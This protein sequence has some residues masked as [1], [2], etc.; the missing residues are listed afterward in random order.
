MISRNIKSINEFDRIDEG[1]LSSLLGGVKNFFTSKKGKVENILKKI[2]DARHEEVSNTISIEKEIQGLTKDNT[3]EYRFALTNL[4]R[5]SRT[6]AA[7]KGQEINSLAKEARSIMEDDPRLEAFFASEMAKIEVE[8]KEKLLK[9]LG[10]ISDSGFLNQIN[11]EFD[12]LVKDANRKASFYD[13]YKE[14]ENYMPSIEIPAKMS[15]D[16]LTF[17]NMPSKEASSFTRSLDETNLNKYYSQIRD[18]FFD[19][20]DK[21]STSIERIRRDKKNAEKQGHDWIIPSLEKEEMNVKYH[22][23]KNID[24]LRSRVNTLEREM[25]NRRYATQTA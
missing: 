8:T 22:L 7:L 21:Y 17:L 25:K 15:D 19:L 23:R 13:D 20:E 4:R 18:F 10:G 2:R 9:N 11:A 6:Y 16:V 5:Q 14:R 12:S 24:K 3:P 1:I